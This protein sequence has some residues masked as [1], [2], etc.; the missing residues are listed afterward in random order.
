MRCAFPIGIL[1]RRWAASTLVG[2]VLALGR[3]MRY[4]GSPYEQV[5]RDRREGA[6]LFR[7]IFVVV[8]GAAIWFFLVGP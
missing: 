2:P 1:Y 3:V 5:E 6:L 4:R 8:L 7:I